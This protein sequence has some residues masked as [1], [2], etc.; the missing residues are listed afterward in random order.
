ME[1][2]IKKLQ[3][4]IANNQATIQG[5]KLEIQ[6]A[7][8][9]IAKL[10][11]QIY[12]IQSDY[13]DLKTKYIKLDSIQPKAIK[14]WIKTQ[15]YEYRDVYGKS[16]RIFM[17]KHN[18]VS[19][20]SRYEL[21]K[22][23]ANDIENYN[24]QALK[25]NQSIISLKNKIL[26]LMDNDKQKIQVLND[27]IKQYQNNI[28]FYNSK[29]KE[30]EGYI[31]YAKMQ[32]KQIINQSK[33]QQTN[34]QKQTQQQKTTNKKQVVQASTTSG[35]INKDDLIKLGIMFIASKLLSQK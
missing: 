25:Q 17:Y 16:H 12:D 19:T 6:N 31:E 4:Y 27:A 33:N 35:N 1:D 29:I 10:R 32:I 34:T 9:Q 23:I 13:N 14:N 7:N 30:I 26:T 22:L 5:L 24:R 2:Q 21:I 8:A 28:D 3:E 18:P 15:P 20:S 11:H